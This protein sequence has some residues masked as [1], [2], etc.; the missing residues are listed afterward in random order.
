MSK[1][2]NQRLTDGLVQYLLVMRMFY[3]HAEDEGEPESKAVL[4]SLHSDSPLWPVTSVRYKLQHVSRVL[5]LTISL[6]FILAA[7]VFVHLARSNNIC[8]IFMSL[9]YARLTASHQRV[10][11]TSMQA[12]IMKDTSMK[13]MCTSTQSKISMHLNALVWALSSASLAHTSTHTCTYTWRAA[14]LANRPHYTGGWTIDPLVE[15][16]KK[17]LFSSLSPR[18][19]DMMS[20]SYLPAL[21]TMATNLTCI[22]QT[23]CV[24]AA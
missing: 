10:W 17:S 13:S 18:M 1:E 2:W 11:R 24:S 3:F 23:V 21:C 5:C 20:W 19:R 15:E 7:E 22:P 16:L 9:T 12:D 14:H 8:L 6:L 4:V